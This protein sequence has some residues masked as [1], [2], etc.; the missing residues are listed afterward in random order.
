MCQIGK[1]LPIGRIQ[2]V[3]S[4]GLDL[5]PGRWGWASLCT[6]CWMRFLLCESLHLFS[7][8]VIGFPYVFL[9]YGS[10]WGISLCIEDNNL[11]SY[12]VL[13]ASCLGGSGL[14]TLFWCCIWHCSLQGSR[15][16]G[17]D[18]AR[19]TPVCET[20]YKAVSL[21]SLLE[22]GGHQKALFIFLRA[23]EVAK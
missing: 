18:W 13:Q 1:V 5:F 9:A 10:V 23:G 19:V 2:N 7:C 21:Q 17:P 11:L 6:S 3:T 14:F 16:L 4:G 8:W 12:S 22:G 20:V 15:D